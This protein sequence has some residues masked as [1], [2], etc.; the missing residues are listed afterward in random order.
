PAL[1][2]ANSF[3]EIP[4]DVL[5]ATQNGRIISCVH[6]ATH[7]TPRTST[8]DIAP[9]VLLRGIFFY[10]PSRQSKTTLGSRL[11]QAPPS[12]R[13]RS[14]F[15]CCMLG[16]CVEAASSPGPSIA[17]RSI[18]N[19]CR[20]ESQAGSRSQ[21]IQVSSDPGLQR[22]RSSNPGVDQRQ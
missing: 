7:L 21:A 18:T 9:H 13:M 1:H 11:V 8:T 22:S 15:L 20:V 16:S 19:A 10:S 3:A 17:P 14:G 12:G 2:R 5:P 4:G 6:L